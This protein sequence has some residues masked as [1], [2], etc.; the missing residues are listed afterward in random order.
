MARF[1]LARLPRKLGQNEP[2]A[3]ASRQP[4]QLTEIHRL[5]RNQLR[6]QAQHLWSIPVLRQQQS[7][8]QLF[9]CQFLQVWTIDK[10]ARIACHDPCPAAI[11]KIDKPVFKHFG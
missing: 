10:I 3:L 2:D 11:R 7:D 8:H 6:C 9:V 1:Y 4:Y 5:L